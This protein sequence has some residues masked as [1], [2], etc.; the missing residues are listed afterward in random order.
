MPDEPAEITR[1]KNKKVL[2]DEDIGILNDYQWQRVFGSPAP[3]RQ[4]P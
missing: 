1:L 4:N 2:T 3:K